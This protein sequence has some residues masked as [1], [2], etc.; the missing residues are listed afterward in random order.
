MLH[1]HGPSWYLLV[2]SLASPEEEPVDDFLHVLE[3]LFS[4]DEVWP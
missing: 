4:H 2:E 3:D 1:V